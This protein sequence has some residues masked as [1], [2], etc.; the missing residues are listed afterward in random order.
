MCVPEPPTSPQAPSQ[1][2]LL[3]RRVCAVLTVFRSQIAWTMYLNGYSA[4]IQL[5]TA[6][7]NLARCT[8]GPV[9]AKS[10]QAGETLP[11][12]AAE[13]IRLLKLFWFI[14]VEHL[15]STEGTPAW[16]WCQHVAYSFATAA[17]IEEFVCE[18]G[19]FQEDD[20][21]TVARGSARIAAEPGKVKRAESRG[22]LGVGK[23]ETDDG[24][25]SRGKM[26]D[27]FN[28][29]KT[30]RDQGERKLKDVVPDVLGTAPGKTAGSVDGVQS[31]HELLTEASR[32]FLVDPTRAKPAKVIMWLNKHCSDVSGGRLWNQEAINLQIGWNRKPSICR[33][34]DPTFASPPVTDRAQG[35]APC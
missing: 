19:T 29:L 9:L 26:V 21:R 28:F 5:R 10:L 34:A 7:M 20:K 15:R 24:T 16:T 22:K 1:L 17:E 27:T 23:K 14:V 12:E 11:E 8:I 4:C 35:G 2:A 31:T 13:V 18:H 33:S 25:L 30:H 6:S 32:L 3:H